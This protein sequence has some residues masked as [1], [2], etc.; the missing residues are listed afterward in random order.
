MRK[1]LKQPMCSLCATKLVIVQGSAGL[2][3][4]FYFLSD[5]LELVNEIIV[6][7]GEQQL[8]QRTDQLGVRLV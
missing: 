2:D 6:S 3:G 7:L 5:E 8:A 1:V 4:P